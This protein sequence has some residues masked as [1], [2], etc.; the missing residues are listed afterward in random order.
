[1]IP[2]YGFIESIYRAEPS[3]ITSSF[4]TIYLV[5]VL[6]IMQRL[7]I[8]V[9]LWNNY[10]GVCVC[11]YKMIQSRDIVFSPKKERERERDRVKNFHNCRIS[12][13]YQKIKKIK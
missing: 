7:K 5:L 3:L 13:F 6:I 10:K 1:M 8:M 11:L 2:G 4:H 9:H 12:N